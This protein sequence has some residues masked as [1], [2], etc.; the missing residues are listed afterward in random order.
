MGRFMMNGILLAHGYPIINVPAKRQ[1]EFNQLMLEFYDTAEIDGMNAFLR[2]CVNQRI[3]E[4][5]MADDESK[6]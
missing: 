2:S 6:V 4:N 5:F 1:K 3:I